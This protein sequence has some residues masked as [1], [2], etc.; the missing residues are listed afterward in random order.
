MPSYRCVH[1]QH[2]RQDRILDYGPIE[3]TCL[4]HPPQLLVLYSMQLQLHLGA[5]LQCFSLAMTLISRPT[6]CIKLLYLISITEECTVHDIHCFGCITCRRKR[7]HADKSHWHLEQNIYCMFYCQGLCHV[8]G[9]HECSAYMKNVNEQHS[10]N[11]LRRQRLA[12]LLH[13]LW[14]CK[15]CS[16]HIRVLVLGTHFFHLSFIQCL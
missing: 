16:V 2:A 13:K 7:P 10:K 12:H 4:Y 6:N 14:Q 3:W 8:H 9:M 5:A 1:A 15:S 11:L